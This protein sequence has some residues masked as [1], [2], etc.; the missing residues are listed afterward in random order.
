MNQIRAAFNSYKQKAHYIFWGIA[1]ILTLFRLYLYYKATYSIDMTA[2]Y[3][4]Q[5]LIHYAQNIL[6]G[7]W[8]GEY[9]ATTLSKGI[10]YSLFLVLA[11]KLH[12]PYS[13]LFGLFNSLASL[14]ITLSLKP[15]AKNHAH[16]LIVY[17]YFLF[18]PIGF[19][20]EYATRIYRNAIVIPSVIIIVACLLAIYFRK[21]RSIKSIL[22]WMTILS[23]IFPFYWFIRED[24]IWLV[25]FVISAL[26]ISS[27]QIILGPNFK[28]E[29]SI[30]R[31]VDQLTINK[32]KAGKLCLFLLPVV[33]FLVA[34][35]SLGYKN[36]EV[37]GLNT[38]N[39]RSSG[40]F[41]QVM[42]N[43]I[44]LDDGTD[45]N[46]KNSR[47]WVSHEAL[48]RA[49]EA[50]PT[51]SKEA[52]RIKELYSTHP[53]T[54]AGKVK[55]LKGDII[56]WALR[57]VIS[58]SGYYHNNAKETNEFWRK[59]NLELNQAYKQGSL[60][61]KKELYLM[62]TGD[63]KIVSDVP[64]LLDFFRTAYTYNLFYKNFHQGGNYSFGTHDEVEQAQKLL[65]VPLLNN[66]I[67]SE[68]PHTPKLVLS[69]TAKIATLVITLYQKS[70]GII[71]TLTLISVLFLLIGTFHAKTEKKLYGSIL[72]IFGGLVLTQFLFLFGV[73][74]FCSYSPEQK[75]YFL[76][77]YTGAGVPIMQTAI[78]LIFLGMFRIPWNRLR[79]TDDLKK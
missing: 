46:E 23:F 65:R 47:I 25:P 26:V 51:F 73:S 6:K 77:V 13:I 21:Y 69:K 12:L 52:D 40:E 57:D 32:Q 2:A 36:E 60:K 34:F 42:K 75:D 35:Q 48:N 76:S 55:E 11:N 3:D 7:D 24:S 63:G 1:I 50:S 33:T 19:T 72:V 61:K 9:N 38:V 68:D 79:A 14:L 8:L 56:F 15:I 74:W 29:K 16:L 43:L 49:V 45:I 27:F 64:V 39:D 18:S 4:D 28:I 67:N 10:S 31:M 66:W 30:K 41:A 44:R 53:W 54:K 78:S 71:L 70:S 5:L 62:G 22:P 58:E 17:L 37:Y 59:V 20:N